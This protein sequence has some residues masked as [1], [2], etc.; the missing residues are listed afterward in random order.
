MVR[1]RHRARGQRASLRCYADHWR[2]EGYFHILNP[3]AGSRIS[4]NHTA[5][6]L[7]RAIAIR[8]VIAWRIQLMVRLR[9]E[10]AAEI[11]FSDGELRVLA[12]P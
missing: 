5:E 4:S 2:I 12:P 8:I 3:A 11:L 9:R 1:P 6:R 7:E 10:V